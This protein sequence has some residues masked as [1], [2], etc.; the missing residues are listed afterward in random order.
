LE[1]SLSVQ[2]HYRRRFVL[3]TVIALSSSLAACGGST[4]QSSPP[5][6][7]AG[8]AV[9][10]TGPNAGAQVPQKQTVTGTA[11]AIPADRDLWIFTRKKTVTHPQ[12]DVIKVKAD[13]TW[14][15]TAYVGT[16]SGDAG[17]AFD[18]IVYLVPKAGT[19]SIRSYLKTAA[20]TGKY[21]GMTPPAG[22]TAL[23][24]VAVVK[25]G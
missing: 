23:A 8:A 4:S 6:G 16:P 18:I 3:L 2:H 15:Q 25:Q 9:A 17:T 14:T 12:S 10:I 24:K 5:S 7:P 13:G 1:V 19:P 11:T 21:P 20:K 22:S